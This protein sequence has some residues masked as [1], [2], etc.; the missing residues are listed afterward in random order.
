MVN[1]DKTMKEKRI[2]SKGLSR[3]R[4][5][6]WTILFILISAMVLPAASY[7]ISGD[8][9][10]A[11]VNDDENQRAN[12]WRAV[13]QGE[14]GYSAVPGAESGVF[15]NNGGQNWRQVR[16]DI[17]TRY[18]GWTIVISLIVIAMFYLVRG[19]IK[20]STETSGLTVPRWQLWERVMHWYTA[21]LFVV[22]TI[23]GLSMLFGRSV[24]I[25]MLGAK[26][27]SLWANFSIN[28]HN[29][30][31]PFFTIG[32]FAMLL[33]WVKNNI[34]NST[35]VKWL[36]TGGGIIGNNHPSAGKLNGGEK[37]WYWVVIFVGLVAVCGTGLA[38]IGWMAQL[39][40]GDTS[41]ATMQTMHQIHSI[42]AIIWTAIFFGHVYIGTIGTEGA[43]D[44]MATGRVSAEW[45]KQHHDLW[46]EDVKD[47]AEQDS[48][49]ED[50]TPAGAETSTT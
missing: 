25:P 34:P 43:L 47:Q 19:K 17:I 10:Y 30:V 21:I 18:G 3:V 11:Q 15:I 6:S 7:L 14:S 9:A 49:Q 2:R 50:G 41:R 38:L 31:G 20:L 36:V 48:G 26:G 24:L 12:F 29:V 46:Y 35:D 4:A 32:V 22:L 33:F 45:A 42:A 1:T 13:R 8:T 5:M 16:N 37:I 28:V 44:G 27:F 39:G 40:F 23:T